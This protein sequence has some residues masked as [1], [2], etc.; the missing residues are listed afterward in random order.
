MMTMVSVIM[1]SISDWE[2]MKNACEIL[3][4]FGVSYEK[5]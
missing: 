4:E 5:K 2:T 3:E 1:G